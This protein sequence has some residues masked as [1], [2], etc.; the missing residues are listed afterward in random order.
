MIAVDTNILVY[1]HRKES[2]FHGEAAA[3]LK[4]LAEGNQTWSIPWP[5]VYEFF[6]VVTHPKIW[7]EAATSPERASAQLGV[8][9]QSPVVTPLSETTGFYEILESYLTLPRVRGPVVHDARIAAL[10]VAHGVEQLLTKD[11]DFSLFS[12]LKIKDPFPS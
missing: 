8:W 12:K 6:S 9:L 10:C 11:R 7:K 3:L 2:R 1:A 4:E 5:C